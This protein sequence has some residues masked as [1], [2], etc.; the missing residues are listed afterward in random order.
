[1]DT[2][3]GLTREQAM[4]K[5]YKVA[6]EGEGLRQACSQATWNAVSEVLGIKNDLIFKLSSALEGGGACTAKVACGA[7]SGAMLAFSYFFGRTYDQWLRSE[8]HLK[9]SFLGQKLYEKFVQEWGSAI[10]PEI[11]QKLYGRNFDF[12][13]KEDFD[14]FE[15]MGAHSIGCTVVC[16]KVSAWTVDILWDEIPKGLDMSMI[17]GPGD[18]VPK[19]LDLVKLTG[20]KGA[21]WGFEKKP[22]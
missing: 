2:I 21:G 11:H 13:N 20:R 17:P 5:A 3:N 4:E 15:E 14:T 22:K 10:C 12:S 7:W 9:S 16:A 1:M 19:D 18:E 6:F 8:K